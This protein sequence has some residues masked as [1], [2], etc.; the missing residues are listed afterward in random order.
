M[1]LLY[2]PQV[3]SYLM[4]TLEFPTK[5]GDKSSVPTIHGYL[6]FPKSLVK[7][8]KTKWNKRRIFGKEEMNYYLHETASLGNQE[9]QLKNY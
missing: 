1:N 5:A 6:I 8:R 2:L 9:N 7:S 4:I 3:S